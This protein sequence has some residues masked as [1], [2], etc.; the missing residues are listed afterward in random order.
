[1]AGEQGLEVDE[2]GFRTLMTEQRDRAKADA[3]SKK[4]KWGQHRGLHPAAG[5]GGRR[6]SPA[7]RP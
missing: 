2:A 6:R 1:M 5:R 7:S 3:R 4:G